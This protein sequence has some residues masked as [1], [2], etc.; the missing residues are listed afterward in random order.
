MLDSD[1]DSGLFLVYNVPGG[2]TMIYQSRYILKQC[3]KFRNLEFNCNSHL[4]CLYDVHAT[5]STVPIEKYKDEAEQLLAHLVDIG[6]LVRTQ[7]GYRMTAAGM[8]TL[9]IS[10]IRIGNFLLRS[11]LV[12]VVLSI[13]TS[14]ITLYITGL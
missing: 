6:C 1:I 5:S 3:R 13:L 12:P 11:V 14:L 9:Q 2:D 8:H 4:H 7:F 10:A